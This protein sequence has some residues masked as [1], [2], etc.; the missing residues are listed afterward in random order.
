MMKFADLFRRGFWNLM[1]E[2]MEFRPV[3]SLC[4]SHTFIDGEICLCLL[5]L[6]M[7][8]IGNYGEKLTCMTYVYWNILIC[9]LSFNKSAV[10]KLK[11]IYFSSKYMFHVWRPGSGLITPW[12]N[13]SSVSSIFLSCCLNLLASPPSWC[14]HSKASLLSPGWFLSFSLI[15]CQFNNS[16]TTRPAQEWPHSC[17][18]PWGLKL[19]PSVDSSHLGSLSLFFW[20]V[21]S[22]SVPTL[23]LSLP[24]LL[25]WVFLNPAEP[26]SSK[27]LQQ[28]TLH[29]A[30]GPA[31]DD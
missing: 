13:S 2:L 12:S 16:S 17:T 15:L 7:R 18:N 14:G 1:A 28:L 5:W 10:R 24:R 8:L 27:L 31:V 23:A 6:L 19:F 29:K 4:K 21:R 3:L 22:G 26:Q 11:N 9:L 30:C 20:L 25:D